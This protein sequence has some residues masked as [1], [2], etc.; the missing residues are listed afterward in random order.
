MAG[1][2]TA[3]MAMNEAVMPAQLWPGIRIH[4][5]DMVQ[6]PGIPMPGMAAM[7]LYQRIVTAA[8]I[9]KTSAAA[10]INT[11]R[12]F[13]PEGMRVSVPAVMAQPFLYSSWRCHQM[14]CS[15]RPSGARSSH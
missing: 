1:I 13:C 7:D 2:I 6:P 9:T 4:A 15:L 5:M 10:A 11:R 3:H 14:P 8:L 12:E